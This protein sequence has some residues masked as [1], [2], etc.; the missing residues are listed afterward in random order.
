MHLFFFASAFLFN[1]S[2]STAGKK[3]A[4]VVK[5]VFSNG[6]EIMRWGN[7]MEEVT[8]FDE[9]EKRVSVCVRRERERER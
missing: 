7:K 1:C 9:R 3:R 8:M 6:A 5:L 4:V 2:S